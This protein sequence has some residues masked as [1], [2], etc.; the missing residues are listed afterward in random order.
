MED[1]DAA[2]AS[3]SMDT[4]T[5]SQQYTTVKT[6]TT[7]SPVLKFGDFSFIDESIGDFEGTDNPTTLLNALL[8]RGESLFTDVPKS[9]QHVNQR[10]AHLHYLTEKVMKEGGDENH[11]ALME[12]VELRSFYDN[13][14]KTAF[15][16]LL[17]DDL[18][19]ELKDYDCYRFLIDSFES[20]CGKFNDYGFKYA[21]YLRH[22]CITGDNEE[23]GATAAKLHDICA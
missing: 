12:E 4:E 15:P 1:T 11:A 5:L 23:I 19:T 2:I 8:F 9:T 22:V 16:E 17:M 18:E 10:D 20:D 6:E 7:R 3:G 21:K 13:T 14:F